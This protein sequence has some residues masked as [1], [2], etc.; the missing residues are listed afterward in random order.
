[1]KTVVITGANRGIGLELTKRFLEQGATVY[2]LCRQSS[3]ELNS[4]KARV[5]SGIDVTDLEALKKA[6][7]EVE[8]AV[9]LLIC[10]AGVFTNED[11]RQFDQKAIY[12]CTR[13]FEVNTL[14]PLKTVAAFLSKLKA[15]SKVAMIT[16]RMGSIEDNTSGGYLGYRMSKCALNM[17]TRSLM[18]DLK[19]EGIALGLFHPGWVQTEMTGRTGHLTAEES[20]LLLINRMSELNLETSGH[21]WHPEGELLPW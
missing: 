20:S 14:G 3:T 16:S 4:T 10:N 5:I 19:P 15:G 13:Q 12:S 17:A 1:M 2:G 18:L 6:S 9:A 7:L 8:G 21:F 11:I